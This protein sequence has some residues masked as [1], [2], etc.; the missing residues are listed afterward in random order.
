MLKAYLARKYDW[1]CHLKLSRFDIISKTVQFYLIE[2]MKSVK[3]TFFNFFPAKSGKIVS[4][5]AR[6]W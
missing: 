5:K 4:D 1:F 2:I 3:K 6:S